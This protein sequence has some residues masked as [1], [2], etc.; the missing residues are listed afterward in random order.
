MGDSYEGTAE[1]LL[2]MNGRC[3]AALFG[4][5]GADLINRATEASQKGTE[6]S[7]DLQAA[8]VSSQ[9]HYPVIDAV[10]LAVAYVAAYETDPASRTLAKQILDDLGSPEIAR[11]LKGEPHIVRQKMRELSEEGLKRD[12]D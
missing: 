11:V 1:E 7:L 12:Q 10:Q 6:A 2:K 3:G 8:V 4:S 9:G 5:E